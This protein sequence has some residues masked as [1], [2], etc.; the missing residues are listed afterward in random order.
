MKMNESVEF[1][2]SYLE[3]HENAEPKDVYKLVFQSFMGPAHLLK[4]F[5]QAE[6][7][8]AEEFEAAAP[9]EGDVFEPLL[10]DCEMVRV[11]LAAYKAAAGEPSELWRA[12]SL[13]EKI[14]E[15]DAT[16]F[17]AAWKGVSDFLKR[18][19]FDRT[20][21]ELLDDFAEGLEPVHHSERFVRKENPSY[22]VVSSRAIDGIGGSLRRIFRES[23]APP[24]T[25]PM[26]DV[27]KDR[28]EHA[29]DID[30][31]GISGLSYPIIVLDRENKKQHTVATVRMSVAL[32]SRWRGTHMSRFIEILNR[33]RGEI[34]H[35]QMKAILDEVLRQF[36][37]HAA[38]I[39]IEFPY[40][41]EKKAPVS[42]APSLM[43]YRA[44]FDGAIE[45]GNYRFKLGVTT[46]VTTLCPCSKEISDEGAHSQRA[47]IYIET[48]S[49]SFIWI[50]EL[51]EI[52]ERAGSA[53]VFSLLKRE[54][55]KFVSEMAYENPRFVED[56]A[57][58]IARELDS[59]EDITEY[60]VRV[61]SEESIHN[62]A[63]FARISAGG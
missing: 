12:V 15:P 52:A 5:F 44:V 23:L 29:I 37:A 34:T 20:E 32:P 61:V 54:D 59:R 3:R 8:F 19:D 55:E 33:Y 46:P 45:G 7:A 53:P 60:T 2:K 49:S 28:P 21:I 40:F 62:H 38:Y 31:V 30:R 58:M 51:V 47:R 10:P 25:P 1:V 41:L 27:A 4:N 24:E 50:E 26:P 17:I 22:R 16:G 35:V 57:R 42:G 9:I 13:T 14:F 18:C 39:T 63:A 43:E 6:N 36:D 11:N 48:V 56:V